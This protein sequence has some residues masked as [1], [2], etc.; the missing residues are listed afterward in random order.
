VHNGHTLVLGGG[1]VAGVAW[2]TGILAGLADA[3]Q[4]VT[5]ADLVIGTSAGSTVAAQ[6]GSGLSLDE[7]YR[8]QAQPSL[9]TRELAVDLDME[10]FGAQLGAL[11]QGLT[12]PAD[13][14]R[15]IG[16]FALA[17][18]TP[19]PQLRRG[20]VADRLPSHQWPARRL[21]IVAV[22]AETGDARIFDGDSGVE[23]VDAVAASCAVAGIWPPVVIEGRPYIDGGFRS[24]DNADYAAGSSRAVILLPLG[25]QAVWPQEKSFAEVVAELRDGGCEVVVIEPDEASRAAIGTNPLDPATRT[26]AAEAGRAQGRGIVVTA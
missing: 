21:M 7:L 11:L 19:A 6:L 5:D 26:P 20:I 17:A 9:Q 15:A 12:S 24:A 4:D 14:R 22:D 10:T 25:S 23:L 13:M 3:G 8:R 2:I 18:S 16:K 1:G